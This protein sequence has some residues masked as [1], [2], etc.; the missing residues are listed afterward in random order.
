MM[1]KPSP[2][3]QQQKQRL[4]EWNRA[5]KGLPKPPS[6]VT[7]V[8]AVAAEALE[9]IAKPGGQPAT[10]AAQSKVQDTKAKVDQPKVQDIGKA[11]QPKAK[12]KPVEPTKLVTNPAVVLP[13]GL[14]APADSGTSIKAGAGQAVAGTEAGKTEIK[15]PDQVFAPA[16][17]G[18]PIKA[19]AGQA[20]AGTEAGKTEIKLPDQVFAPADSG[21]PIQAGAGQAVAG[22][23]AGKTEIKLPDQVFAPANSGSPIKAGAGQA[24]AGK[25]SGKLKIKLPNQ[26]FAPVDSGTTEHAR[27]AEPKKAPV[28]PIEKIAGKDLSD[29]DKKDSIDTRYVA[30]DA[31]VKASFAM[32]NNELVRI[33]QVEKGQKVKMLTRTFITNSQPMNLHSV[34]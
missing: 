21:T 32:R 1:T 26:V 7:A 27:A 18:S 14:F 34:E 23:E 3:R 24:V 25:E 28:G 12:T 30:R 22:P 9:A 6:A 29:I 31:T 2:S 13:G 4:R 5:L 19:G 20:V 16:N 33:G 8:E 15:L 17:S 10:K 11:A